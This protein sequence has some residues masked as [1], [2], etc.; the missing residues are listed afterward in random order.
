MGTVIMPLRS[1]RVIGVDR[2]STLYICGTRRSKGLECA[3]YARGAEEPTWQ[4]V[5]DRS[6]NLP[7]GG[8]LLPGR[9]Y[10]A[11]GQG[12]LLAVGDK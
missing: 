6:S 11:T 9:E 10:V 1:S 5:L 7:V 2:N 4:V 12:V 8:A 3:A